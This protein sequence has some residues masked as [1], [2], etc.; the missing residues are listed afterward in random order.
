MEATA[1]TPLCSLSLRDSRTYLLSAL[2]IT[3][4][5]LLP[6]ICHLIPQGGLIWLPIYFFTLVAAY[7]YGAAAGL[8]TAVI[9]PVINNL[10]FGM[11]PSPLLP[12]IVIKSVLL[13]LAAAFISGK[14]RKVTLPCVIMAVAAYQSLGTMAEWALTGSL[15]AAMQDVRLGWPGMLLQIFGGYAVLRIITNRH[16]AAS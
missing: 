4:N 16:S 7:R 14:S 9:S 13:A 3:G 5:I 2:F 1:T 12:A 11:P 8:L 6:Q 10:L 15:N